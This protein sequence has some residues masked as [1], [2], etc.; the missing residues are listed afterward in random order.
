MPLTATSGLHLFPFAFFVLNIDPILIQ[1]GPL[2]IHW[3]GLMYVVAISIGLYALMRWRRPLG[4]HEDQLWGLFIWTA[5][6]GLIGGRLYFVIQQPNLVQ[7]YLLDPIN[8]I[9]VWQGGMAFFGAIFLGTLT[10]FIIAP[11]YGLSRWIAIDGGA[12]FAV[13]G[14]I[15]GRVGNIING[16][17]LGQQLS[18][19][20]VN[21]P[22]NVCAHATCIASVPDAHLPFWAIVYLNHQ[23]FATTGIAYQP[24]P[25]FEMLMNVAILLLLWPVRLRLPR[26]RAGYFFVSYFFLYGLSQ[27]IVFFA[28]GS[29]PFTPF[30]GIN[31]LKQ[32]QWTGIA[33]MLICIPLFALVSRFSA[34]WTYTAAHPVPWPTAVPSPTG[35]PSPAASAAKQQL[36]SL[37]KPVVAVGTATSRAETEPALDLPPWRPTRPAAGALR[38]VF[39][40]RPA[41]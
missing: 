24:A 5:I 31:G 16:D 33:V 30:L 14:Q 4:I 18:S 26:V 41:E 17:I 25:V 39:G 22:A 38:N 1:L 15:F 9:A 13:V 34:P 23:S 40:A 10:L 7:N 6:A 20:I 37:A 11:R 8:I 12:L 28:R 32:A 27:F 35:V 3:Y 21:I 2:A 19:G 29:E 36:R